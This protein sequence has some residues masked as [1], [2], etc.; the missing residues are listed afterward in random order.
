VALLTAGWSLKP[1]EIE[2]L[3]TVLARADGLAD[4]AAQAGVEPPALLAA[5]AALTFSE[6]FVLVDLAIQTHA[7]AAAAVQPY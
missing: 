5:V 6:K 3:E 4:S 1:L 2:H 7:P